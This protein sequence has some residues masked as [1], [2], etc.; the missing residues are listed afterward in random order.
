MENK[1]NSCRHDGKQ[2][3]YHSACTGCGIKEH[4]HYEPKQEE[5][6][7]EKVQMTTEQA[8]QM[9]DVCGWNPDAMKDLKKHGYIKKTLN[10]ITE[11]A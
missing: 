8:L 9:I 11:G 7:S 10:E 3:I 1:C 2:V 6:M 5:S 4:R